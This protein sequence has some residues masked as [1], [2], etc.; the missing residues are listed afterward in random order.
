ML[1]EL[2]KRA[3]T[4]ADRVTCVE[5]DLDVPLEGILRREVPTGRL[6]SQHCTGCG[7][8]G[9]LAASLRYVLRPQDMF[10]AESPVEGNLQEVWEGLR[11]LGVN[12]VPQA[13][14]LSATVLRDELRN[15]GLAVEQL[16][17]RTTPVMAS[18]ELMVPYLS[19]LL[20]PVL[21]CLPLCSP[22]PRSRRSGRSRARAATVPR[23]WA[24]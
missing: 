18:R 6:V 10:I 15:H 1:E 17:A 9:I 13:R 23:N 8:L 24:R 19:I 3:G 20:A 4:Q 14:Y 12:R 2:R 11:M 7:I 16:E 5:A 21:T 22:P